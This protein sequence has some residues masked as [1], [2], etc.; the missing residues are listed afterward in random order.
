VKRKILGKGGL[1]TG[2]GILRAEKRNVMDPLKSAN[3]QNAEIGE[4]EK[5][6]T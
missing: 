2:A 6:R 5:G 3:G 1:E 4:R